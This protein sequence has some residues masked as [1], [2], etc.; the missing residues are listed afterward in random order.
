MTTNIIDLTKGIFDAQPF[1]QFVGAQL[2][3]ADGNS[4]ELRLPIQ[5][6][7]Q[8][9]HGYVHGG[10]LSYLADNAIT[11]AGGIALGGDALT[12]EFKINYVKPAA[13]DF[14]SARATSVSTGKRQAVCRCEL[15]AVSG[16]TSTLCAL[17]Q[18]TVIKKG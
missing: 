4:V 9:Q 14:V 17:A 11:F 2:A 6:N 16:D 3:H 12:S 18:G 10:A 5:K 7:V 15:Y 8:Q 1:S 13:G